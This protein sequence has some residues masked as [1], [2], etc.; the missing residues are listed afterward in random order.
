MVLYFVLGEGGD[1][2][3]RPHL[4]SPARRSID[5]LGART[6]ASGRNVAQDKTAPSRTSTCRALFALTLTRASHSSPSNIISIPIPRHRTQCCVSLQRCAPRSGADRRDA[7]VAADK[8]GYLD[9]SL[10]RRPRGA[11]LSAVTPLGPVVQVYAFGLSRA[12]AMFRCCSTE[13]RAIP[14]TQSGWLSSKQS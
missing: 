11:L 3:V 12:S 1:A 8:V 4:M 13:R 14:R 10:Y 2:P 5:P 7:S 6:P 9:R